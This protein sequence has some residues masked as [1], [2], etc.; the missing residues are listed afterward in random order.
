MLIYPSVLFPAIY[1]AIITWTRLRDFR[2]YRRCRLREQCYYNTAE[3]GMTIGRSTFVGTLVGELSA[4]PVSD[5]ILYFQTKRSGGAF[6]PE[7]RLQA[8]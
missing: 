1:Y 2:S 6:R 8:I 5:R 4:D 3:V 7:A